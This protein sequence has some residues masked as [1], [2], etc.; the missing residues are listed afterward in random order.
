MFQ[1]ISGKSL[2]V[3]SPQINYPIWNLDEITNVK[4]Y[5]TLVFY[6]ALHN[7]IQCDVNVSDRSSSNSAQIL[8]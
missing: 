3:L 1:S 5:L 6:S 4:M 7:F 8:Y 2:V